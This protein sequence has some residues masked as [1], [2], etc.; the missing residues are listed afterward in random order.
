MLLPDGVIE[1]FP[2]FFEFVDSIWS[3]T[4]ATLETQRQAKVHQFQQ[5]NVFTRI[6]LKL[7]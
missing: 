5:V 2:D 6:L 4:V 3:D 1:I 7:F